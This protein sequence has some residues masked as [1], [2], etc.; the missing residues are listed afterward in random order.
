METT[1]VAAE[2]AALSGRLTEGA[3]KHLVGD[4]ATATLLAEAAC[5]A[6]AILLD[7]NLKGFAD[8]RPGQAAQCVRDADVARQRALSR[9]TET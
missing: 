7:L 8:D 4:A 3:G 2:V 5:A 6:A 1:R 9:A